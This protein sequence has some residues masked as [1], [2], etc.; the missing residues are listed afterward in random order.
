ME[1]VKE[2]NFD[3]Y[4]ISDQDTFNMNSTLDFRDT[5]YLKSPRITNK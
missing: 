5:K 4:N 3:P 1:S 2:F